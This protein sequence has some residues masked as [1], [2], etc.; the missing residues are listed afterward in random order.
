MRG[1]ISEAPSRCVTRREALRTLGVLTAGLCAGCSPMRLLLNEHASAVAR[2]PRLEE[3][4]LRS[5][6]ATVIPGAPIDSP[7]LVRPFYDREHPYGPFERVRSVFVG[8]LCR[9]AE[10]R[11]GNPAFD[12][13]D[14][15]QRK[16][17]IEDGLRAD[18]TTRRLYGGAIYLAQITFYAGTFDDAK[19]CP[20][21]EF[22]GAFRPRPLAEIT[23]PDPHRFLPHE[24]TPNGN[25]S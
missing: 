23:Y 6:V 20:L 16:E 21:I 11:F 4:I 8:D 10:G 22:E 25:C 18:G 19:G 13:L 14:D 15:R 5:F 9:R 2:Q 17:V 1:Q 7:D 12:E 24:L 3:R